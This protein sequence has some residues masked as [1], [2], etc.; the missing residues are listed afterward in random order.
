MNKNILA[1][2]AATCAIGTIASAQLDTSDVSVSATVGYES[3]YVFRGVQLAPGSIQASVEVAFAGAYVGVWTNQPVLNDGASGLSVDNEVDFYAGYGFA[4]SD[5]VELDVGATYYV[6]PETPNAALEDTLEVFVGASFD[7]ALSPSIYVYYDFDIE[8]VTVETSIGH[9]ID[10]ADMAPGT[11]IEIGGTLGWVDP[12][13]G[14]DYFYAGATADLVYSF[15]DNASL[16]LGVRGTKN[17]LPRAVG[18][19]RANF[20]YGLSFTAGF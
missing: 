7:L 4:V 14:S 11:S 15:T 10:L 1:A 17:D 6:Y 18:F 12:D 13:G 19:N 20:W 5:L 8:V 2:L 16:S 9:S 3:E